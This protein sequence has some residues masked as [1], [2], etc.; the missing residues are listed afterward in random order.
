M[1]QALLRPC[2]SPGCSALVESGRCATHARQ[3]EQQR[4]SAAHRLYD[5]WWRE[6]T[7]RFRSALVAHGIAP[8][9]GARLPGAPP[10]QDSTCQESGV[11]F[12]DD[13][14]LR[15]YKQRLHTDHI[16]PH[17]GVRERFKN[18]RNLQLLC[19]PHHRAKTRREQGQHD[20][21]DVF[22]R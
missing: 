20:D 12:D 13:A 4:G 15:A 19:P 1:P 11:L 9:C 16:V 18:L 8:V 14:S 3:V 6:L 5:R 22:T 17:E 21:E 2:T 10:T 7:E